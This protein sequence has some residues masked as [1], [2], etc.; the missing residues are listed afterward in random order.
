MIQQPFLSKQRYG[1]M[2]PY[3]KLLM[4]VETPSYKLVYKPH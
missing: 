1:I 4:D 3:L 2:G